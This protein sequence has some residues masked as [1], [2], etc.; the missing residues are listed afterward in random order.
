MDA[1]TFPVELKYTPS[2]LW[3]RNEDGVAMIGLTEYGQERHGKIFFVGLPALGAPV[4]FGMPFGY[5]QSAG[6][7]LTQLFPPVQGEIVAI[8]ESLWMDPSLVNADPFDRGWVVAVKLSDPTELDELESAESYEQIVAGTH[9][10]RRATLA[11]ELQVSPRPAFLIDEQR[12]VLACNGAAERL[13]GLTSKEMRHGP[14][15]SELFG[16]H[17]H[18]TGEA[19]TKSTCPGLCSLMNLEPIS[20][21]EYVVTNARGGETKVK[22]TY[23]PVAEPG[24]ARRAVVVLTPADEDD[25]SA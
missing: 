9:E 19:V 6:Y 20:D 16:C 23:Q 5:L 15:C 24:Q 2:H 10:G 14:L 25:D 3:V 4:Q 21:T 13:I 18:D 1:Y 12:R 7:G 8:N 17:M 22:A 11:P